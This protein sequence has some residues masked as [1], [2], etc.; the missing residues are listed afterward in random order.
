MA[1][2]RRRATE[3]GNDAWAEIDLMSPLAAVSLLVGESATAQAAVEAAA[4]ALAALVEKAVERLRAGGRLVYAGAGSAGMLAQLDAAELQP[5]FGF[6]A[7]R[8][9]VLLAGASMPPAARAGAEDD[10]EAGRAEASDLHLGAADVVLA[11]SASG[12]TP[13]PLAA[14]EVAVEAGALTAALVCNAGSPM[15]AI[16]DHAVELA[17][18]PEVIAGST[19]LKAGTAQ[20]LAL[21]AFSTATMVGL[22]LTFGNAMAAVRA[23]NEKLRDRAVRLLVAAV[24]CEPAA[25]RATLEEAGWEVPVALVSLAAEV[26]VEVARA[27]LAAAGGAIRKAVEGR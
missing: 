17:T 8:T 10:D 20:K 7:E 12:E 16:A 1:G 2:T 18:G 14:L 15:A 13:Y 27:R 3:A 6:A 19:R 25:A 24:G 22:G 5:T 4:P 11:V 9:I 26:D 21:N 23:D